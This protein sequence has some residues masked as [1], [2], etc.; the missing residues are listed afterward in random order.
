[1]T[2]WAVAGQPWSGG[3]PLVPEWLEPWLLISNGRQVLAGQQVLSR[4]DVARSLLL[5]V[6]GDVGLG[7]MTPKA[8]LRIERSR[9]ARPHMLSFAAMQEVRLYAALC[10]C[11]ILRL[12]APDTPYTDPEL[13]VRTAWRHAHGCSACACSVSGRN[14]CRRHAAHCPC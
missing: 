12:N 2:T 11:H 3:G 7:L 10:L 9:P 8:P 1:L 4:H 14:G 13:E 6:R 5:L